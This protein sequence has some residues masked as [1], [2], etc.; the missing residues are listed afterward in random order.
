MQASK[1]KTVGAFFAAVVVAYLLGAIVST[2]TI[3]QNVVAM[4]VPVGWG[5]RIGATLHDL[6]GMAPTYLP[7]IAVG[8]LVAFPL[9]ALIVRFRPNLRSIGYV[10][11]G[12]VAVLAIH[13]AMQA[14]LGMHPLPTTRTVLGLLLQG[15]AGA[16]GGYAFVRITRQSGIAE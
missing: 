16:A 12:A 15:A 7:I 1:L 5:D 8:F 11:A 6:G 13:L 10:L 2:Q 4:E 14:L 9:T 3:L